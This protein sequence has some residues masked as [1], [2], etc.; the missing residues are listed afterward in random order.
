MQLAII[1]DSGAD[2]DKYDYCYQLGKI[3]ARHGLILITG[4]RGGIMEAACQGA[5][6]YGGT[7][8]GILPSNSKEHANPYCKII[9]PTG[10][11]QARNSIVVSSADIV[12]AVGGGAGTLSELA[13]SWIYEKCILVC[14]RFDGSAKLFCDKK[15]D[16]RRDSPIASFDSL[17]QFENQLI[18]ILDENLI[19]RNQL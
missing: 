9:I 18:K 3:T 2:K 17:L 10:L 19:E 7:T 8:V 5:Y 16:Q 1:G 15:I 11:G 4:G 14:S 6:E 12:V 13:F